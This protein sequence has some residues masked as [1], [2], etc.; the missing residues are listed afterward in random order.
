MLNSKL[1][2]KDKQLIFSLKEDN[3]HL[4]KVVYEQYKHIKELVDERDYLKDKLKIAEDKL[5][6]LSKD[7]LTK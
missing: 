7:K 6:E 1:G 5:E 3:K 4:T 2:I